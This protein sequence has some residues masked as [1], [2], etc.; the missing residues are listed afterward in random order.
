VAA[1]GVLHGQALLTGRVTNEN[2]APVAGARVNLTSAVAG[3]GVRL[4]SDSAGGFRFAAPRPGRYS[5]SIDH[6]GYFQ[7]KESPV[8]LREGQNDATFVLT[9]LREVFE[10]LDVSAS[11]P[12]IDPEQTTPQ[13][14]LTG[15][16]ILFIPFSSTNNL[17]NAISLLPGI[18]QDSRGGIHVDGSSEDQVQYTLDGFNIGDPLTGKFESRLSVESVSA[19][20][21]SRARFSAEYGKGSAGAMAVQTPTG[22]DKLRYSATNF[23][24]GVENHKGLTIGNWTPRFNLSG[25]LVRGRA[26]FSDSIDARYDESIVEELPAGKDRSSSWRYSNLL[27][28]QINVTP[29]NIVYTGFLINYWNAPRNGLTYVNPPETTVDRRSRQWFY[30][31][32]DQKYFRSGA[33]L[34]SGVAINRT[35]EREIPQGSGMLMINPEGTQGNQ[36]VNAV[37]KGSRDQWLANLFFPSL[38]WRGRHQLKM[39]TDLDKVGYR[40]NTRRTGYRQYDSF[41]QLLREVHF[42]G[43][44]Q[45]HRS[46]L[47]FAGYVQD[48]WLIHRNVVLEFGLRA[49][50]DTLTNNTSE[51][52]RFGFAWSPGRLAHTK[53]SGGYAIINDATQLRLF[54]RPLDQYS[55]TWT[56][57]AGGFEDGSDVRG[58][59]LGIYEIQGSRFRSPQYRN[60]SLGFERTFPRNFYTR[61]N[62]F[63]KRGGNGFTYRNIVDPNAPPSPAGFPGSAK[64][65][66]TVNVLGNDRRDVIDSA[67]VTV[68]QSFGPEYEWMVSYTRSRALSNGVVDIAVDDPVIVTSNV[69]PMPWDAPNRAMSWGFLPFFHK[70]YGLA[71]LVEWRSGFPF[72]V[73]DDYGRQVGALNSRRYPSYFNSNLHIERRFTFHGH[74]WALRA[75]AN[76]VTSHRNPTG[77]F[78]NAASPRFLT[79]Y[80][81]TGRSFNYRF[82]GLGKVK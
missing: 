58:P 63:R 33:L 64:L 4:V 50:R 77:V 30:H 79:Y 46:N 40:Q 27:R 6:E 70:D 43:N 18:V 1:A 31:V 21:V 22:D 13:E 73:S 61:V 23:F 38:R 75:G 20:E 48:S 57:F 25:P 78:N 15:K 24:P 72:S 68:K 74:R 47:E 12:G 10:S 80:G 32:K 44:G 3:A 14:T 19:V 5:V 42:A 37:R 71:Y 56:Y 67:E 39:G 62:Y 82:R 2:N 7:L 9:G 16:E 52:P 45:F 59:A 55:L 81:S 54:T 53:I 28:N 76:N 36:F 41:G 17:R 51:S 11:P 29:S 26:W 8:E 65:V 49:D 60:F 34:E 35:F 69:G 66:D